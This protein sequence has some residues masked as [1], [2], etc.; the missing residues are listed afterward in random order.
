MKQPRAELTDTI[1]KSAENVRHIRDIRC[2]ETAFAN[3]EN[4]D[5][6]QSTE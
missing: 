2:F 5:E 3:S 6:Q 1:K 4:A